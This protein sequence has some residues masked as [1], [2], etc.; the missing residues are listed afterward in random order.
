MK[1]EVEVR[2]REERNEGQLLQDRVHVCE[3]KGDLWNSQATRSRGG[4]GAGV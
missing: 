2:T 3:R 1:S 4:E